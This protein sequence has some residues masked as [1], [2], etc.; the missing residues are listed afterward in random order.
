MDHTISGEG[1]ELSAVAAAKL[2][3]KKEIAKRQVSGVDNVQWKPQ[4]KFPLTRMG[5]I[6]AAS[7]EPL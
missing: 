6:P 4:K 5:L 1:L 3:L 2:V 7:I